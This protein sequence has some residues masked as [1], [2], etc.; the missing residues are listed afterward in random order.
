MCVCVHDAMNTYSLRYQ[1]KTV[2]H[3]HETVIQS[4]G[5][6]SACFLYSVV[7]GIV[8]ELIAAAAVVVALVVAVAVVKMSVICS[9]SKDEA[10]AVAVVKMRIML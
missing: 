8:L 7:S 10:Y 9:S 4:Y 3:Q 1:H 6:L 2:I 5:S